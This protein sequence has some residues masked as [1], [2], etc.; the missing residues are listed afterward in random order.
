MHILRDSKAS[1]LGEQDVQRLRHD[2]HMACRHL[3]RIAGFL[4]ALE[5][6]Q[7]DASAGSALQEHRRRTDL[8]PWGQ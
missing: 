1:C 4:E 3:G 6:P 7:E 2:F 5:L 8:Q